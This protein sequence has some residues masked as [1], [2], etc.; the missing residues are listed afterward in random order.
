MALTG[1]V[2]PLKGAQEGYLSPDL[3]NGFWPPSA[4]TGQTR[5]QIFIRTSQIKGVFHDIFLIR[6][7]SITKTIKEDIYSICIK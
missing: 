6:F 4:S 5:V 7:T 2:V 1:L 3:L